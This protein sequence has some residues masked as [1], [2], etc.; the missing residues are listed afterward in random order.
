MCDIGQRPQA[1]RVHVEAEF[2]ETNPCTLVHCGEFDAEILKVA[3]LSEVE[4]LGGLPLMRQRAVTLAV[5]QRPFV[6]LLELAIKFPRLGHR[7]D[8]TAPGLLVACP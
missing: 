7:I 6:A 1:S 4:P 5:E 3:L 8:G 2:A